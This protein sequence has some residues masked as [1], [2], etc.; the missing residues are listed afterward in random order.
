MSNEKLRKWIER[1]HSFKMPTKKTKLEIYSKP[2][3]QNKTSNFS[4]KN[5]ADP[6]QYNKTNQK[7][8]SMLL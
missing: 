5:N 6:F 3:A 2:P 4:L 8:Y 1:K 7:I